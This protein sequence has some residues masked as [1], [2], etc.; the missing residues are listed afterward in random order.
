MG[1]ERFRDLKVWQKA[2]Q[3][4]LQVMRLTRSFPAEEKYR[5]V[6]QMCRAAA[7]IPANIA[8]G[9]PRQT[10]RDKAHFYLLAKSSLE[11]LRVYLMFSR[12]LGY[13]PDIASLEQLADEIGAMLY[14]LR[15]R[16]LGR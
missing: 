16:V 11:E 9:F 1:A 3:F 10:G 6:D 5:M 15:E 12:D 7:S 8:E 13:C 4:G 2:Y 14:A